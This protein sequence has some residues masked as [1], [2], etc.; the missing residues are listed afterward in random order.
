M[1]VLEP[2]HGL[3]SFLDKP[4]I[5]FDYVVEIF[6]LTDGDLF[7]FGKVIINRF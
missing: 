4:M 1:K 6:V 5:L 2:K 7:V 3:G